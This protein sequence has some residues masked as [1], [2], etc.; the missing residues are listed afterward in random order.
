MT[1]P[2]GDRDRCPADAEIH[3]GQRTAHLA[4]LVADRP[5]AHDAGLPEVIQ[6]PAL[7]PAIVEERARE[8]IADRDV[9]GD[10]LSALRV[11][12]VAGLAP[13]IIALLRAGPDDA[14]AAHVRL[15]GRRAP[16]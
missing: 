14:V 2:G 16:I 12:P 6:S 9:D 1:A 7:D 13:S 8:A 11:A 15:A 5:V 10:L 4:G 3:R